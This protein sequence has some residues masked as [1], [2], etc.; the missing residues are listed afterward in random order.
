MFHFNKKNYLI[1]FLGTNGCKN[2]T[3]RKSCCKWKNYIIY[4]MLAKYEI[5]KRK[6]S[7]KTYRV[8]RN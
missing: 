2:L 1:E 6:V 4:I 3:N 5:N 8:I 7:C